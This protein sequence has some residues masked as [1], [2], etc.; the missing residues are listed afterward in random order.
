MF[1][2][3]NILFWLWLPIIV[4]WQVE[5]LSWMYRVFSNV[6]P[7]LK[8]MSEMFKKVPMTFL[9]ASSSP[10]LICHTF[11]SLVHTF[12]CSYCSLKYITNE[13]TALIKQAEDSSSNNKVYHFTS[14]VTSVFPF[15][16]GCLG[17]PVAVYVNQR[18][19]CTTKHNVVWSCSTYYP[20]L[21]KAVHWP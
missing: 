1:H 20:N 14:A 18:R 9:C 17:L 13:G 2:V 15:S 6:S 3:R 12:W 4:L 8:L 19:L 21:I 7:C 10:V 11:F 16:Y 5:E